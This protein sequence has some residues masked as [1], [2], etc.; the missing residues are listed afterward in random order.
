MRRPRLREGI[1]LPPSPV[2]SHEPSSVASPAWPRRPPP[3]PHP[4][5]FPSGSNG[6]DRDQLATRVSGAGKSAARASNRT[7]C[8]KMA[9]RPTQYAPLCGVTPSLRNKTSETV[10][11]SRIGARDAECLFP[12]FSAQKPPD[13]DRPNSRPSAFPESC[14][15]AMRSNIGHSE[16]HCATLKAALLQTNS[17]SRRPLR[18]M[19]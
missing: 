1:R 13:R 7:R 16:R 18:W 2:A 8:K 3:V 5:A 15:S 14:R 11:K 9:I 4:F 12:S 10:A 17:E 19:Q 6:I